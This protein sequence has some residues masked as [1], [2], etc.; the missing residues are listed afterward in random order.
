MRALEAVA[1]LTALSFAVPAVAVA[2]PAEASPAQ[3]AP[4][5]DGKLHPDD[6]V[7][8]ARVQAAIK[9]YGEGKALMS[10]GSYLQA[11]AAFE[12]SHA[13]IEYGA[14]LNKISAAY[15][16]GNDPLRALAKARE[17]LALPG[18]EGDRESTANY[19]CGE[20]PLRRE[21][22]ERADRLRRLVGELKLQLAKDVVL[23]EVKVG[24][25]V[26]P[27]RDFPVLVLPGSYVVVLVGA[28]AGQV[29]SHDVVVDGG[30]TFNVYVA[31]FPEPPK[32]PGVDV[33]RAD[34]GRTGVIERPGDGR[35][36]K[37]ILKGVFWGGVGLTAASG[38]A[39]GVLAGLTLQA[40]RKFDELL[41]AGLTADECAATMP[42]DPASGTFFPKSHLQRLERLRPATNAMVGVTAGIGVITVVVGIFAFS[43]RPA[44]TNARL[45]VRRNALAVRF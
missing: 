18:C 41:C 37:R 44:G 8:N 28:K 6:A 33:D 24:D 20:P 3:E 29:R 14:T 27:L 7:W 43:K 26:V 19:P 36:R 5:A 11:A 4:A 12:R 23:R 21:A 45:Q 38:V 13:S 25:R 40:K 9:H 34:G 1:L 31:P 42:V 30:E 2:G 32:D 15:D 10:E 17:Y 16:A 35:R 39:V 22:R